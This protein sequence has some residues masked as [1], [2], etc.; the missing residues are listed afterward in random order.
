MMS[1]FLAPPWACTRLPLA[2]ARAVHMPRHPGRTDK[3]H[4]GDV[5]VIEQRVHRLGAAV[6]QVDHPGGKPA[7][8]N[9]RKIFCIVSGVR[10]E[11]LMMIVFPQATA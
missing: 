10:S 6:E 7:S 2:E 5:G 4:R 8:S 9:R 1:G 11:G 3:G